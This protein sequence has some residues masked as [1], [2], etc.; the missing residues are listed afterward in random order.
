[1][2]QDRQKH[3]P[4]VTV[5]YSVRSLGGGVEKQLASAQ[6][7]HVPSEDLTVPVNLGNEMS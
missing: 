4:S 6:T 1:M 2:D 3:R 5:L 7:Q